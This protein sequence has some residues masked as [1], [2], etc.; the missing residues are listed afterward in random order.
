VTS[1][2]TRTALST[3]SFASLGV[4][5]ALAEVLG[6]DG[7][8]DPFPIQT[9]TLP[10]SLAGRDVLGRGRTGSGK[11]LAFALPLVARL[12]ASGTVTRP[13][14]PRGLVLVPTRELANQVLAVVEPLARTAGLTVMTIFGGVGQNPQVRAL[15][16][17]TDIVIACPGRLEDLVGQGHCDLGSVEITVLDEADHM[18]DLGFLPGVRRLM[19]R[20]P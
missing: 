12:A 9:A 16:A 4:P 1:A 11:T 2:P 17:G 3:H 19:D 8:T 7:I 20:T 13:M 5:T 14:K 10:D 18:A 15:R 6:R